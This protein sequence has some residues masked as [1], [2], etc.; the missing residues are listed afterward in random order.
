MKSLLLALAIL[1]QTAPQ[2]AGVVTGVV[3]GANGMPAPGVRVYAIGV[4]DTLEALNTGTA[5]LEGLT[6]TDASGRYR[7]EV[8]PGRYYIASGSVNAPTFYPGTAKAADARVVTVASGGLVEAIDFSSFVPATNSQPFS[9]TG[10]LSGVIRF[11]DGT[12]AV[13]IPVVAASVSGGGSPSGNF[14][15]QVRGP[16]ALPAPAGTL[17]ALFQINSIVVR[18]GGGVQLLASTDV[19]GRYTFPRTPAD[20][21]YIAAGYAE[22]PTLY[23]GVTDLA[24]AKTLVTTP[25]TN[26]NTLDFSLSRPPAAA[27]VVRGRLTAVGGV[28]LGGIRVDIVSTSSA[29]VT[30]PYGLPSIS[31]ARFVNAGPDGRFEFANLRPGP[32]VVTASYSAVISE[33]RSIVVGDQPVEGVDFLFRASTLSGR[34]LAEDGS[35]IPDVRFFGDAVV[36]TAGNPNMVLST[37]FQVANDGSFARILEPGEYRFFLRALPEEY[38]IMSMTAA[39]VDLMKETLKYAATE[40]VKLDVRVTK[41]TAVADSSNPTVSVNG[42]ILDALTGTL[43][44]AERIIL[45]C[46]ASGPVERFSAPLKSDGSFEFSA[47][48]PGR[49]EVSLRTAASTAGPSVVGSD[50]IV[51]TENISGLEFLS[52]LQVGQQPAVIEFEDG[53]VPPDGFPVRVQYTGNS[54]R[55]RVVAQAFKHAHVATLPL[56]DTYKLSVIDLPEGYVVKS[57]SGLTEPASGSVRPTASTPPPVVI[58]LARQSR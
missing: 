58:T 44:G 27:G 16:I 10:V 53:S 21:Y 23:P 7:L 41:R 43:S 8:S 18:S 6:Q 57:I 11:P 9:G 55:V 1:L 22:S 54:S 3:R 52:A 56:G 34:I 40:P 26:V 50:L 48:P 38:S 14:T 4:R 15:V 28:P 25:T 29:R 31:P 30:S 17:P 13:G 46:R 33:S 20:T 42:R 12:P 5:P 2:S 39:G 51:G 49:Y 45:C 19:R 24:A 36:S 32:Y 35:P 37:I 47:V